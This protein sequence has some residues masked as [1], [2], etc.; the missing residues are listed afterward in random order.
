MIKKMTDPEKGSDKDYRKEFLLKMYEQTFNN[1]NRHIMTSWQAITALISAFVF[2]SLTEKNIISLDWAAFLLLIVI[3]FLVA[4]LIDSSDWYNRNQAIIVNIERQFLIETDQKEIHDFFSK[5]RPGN[6]I[7]DFQIKF[8]FAVALGY[9]IIVLH[10]S[11]RIIPMIMGKKI[12]CAALILYFSVLFIVPWM[13]MYYRRRVKKY[14]SDI[15]NS[16]GKIMLKSTVPECPCNSVLWISLKLLLPLFV[17]LFFAYW[18]VPK[19]AELLL[20]IS[21]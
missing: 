4:Q 18:V 13:A 12:E 6:L 9:A 2:L 16:P 3:V 5:H 15:A 17:L 21:P 19:D 14:L 20:K 11:K 1:I 8:Y 10:F 7:Q